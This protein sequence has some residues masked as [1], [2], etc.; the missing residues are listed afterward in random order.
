MSGEHQWKGAVTVRVAKDEE[1]VATGQYPC[2]ATLPTR[3][4]THIPITTHT[5]Q[6]DV[7]DGH[8]SIN[9]QPSLFGRW[10]FHCDLPVLSAAQ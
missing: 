8:S 1:C 5:L 7:L 3:T 9:L 2:T 6:T 4:L 10:N